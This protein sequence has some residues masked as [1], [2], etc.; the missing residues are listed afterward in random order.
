MK[1]IY[2]LRR[3]DGTG[4]IKIGCSAY[5]SARFYQLEMDLRVK[6]TALAVAP[7]DFATEGNL[8][9][10]FAAHRQAMDLCPNR[11]HVGGPTEWFSPA[12]ELLAYIDEVSRTGKISLRDDERQELV[13]AE[14]Y[15]AGET[16]Q[17][18]ASDLSIT[19]ERVRQVLRRERVASFGLRDEHKRKPEPLSPDELEMA[20]LYREGVR[21]RELARKFPD[22]CL[23]TVLRRTGTETRPAGDWLR[24]DDNDRIIA[25]IKQMYP[26]G[27]TS[28][29]IADACNLPHQ[30]AVYRYLR[31]A[32][33]R[34]S[35]KGAGT[36]LPVAEI[37]GAYLGGMTAQAIAEIHGV[38]HWTIK[39]LLRK[40]G[41]ARTREQNEAV[42]I[43]A[44][45][46]ANLERKAA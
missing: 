38:A 25:T 29:E 11:P 2:F 1:Q 21:P 9:R 43:A 27:A 3:A 22:L 20:R 24:R 30:T 4:P 17:A 36:T 12:P 16:L 46:Q 40:H 5:P 6:F 39:A 7:G 28:Q 45:R 10:K 42:R 26:A 41:A 33:I 44:V 8:H 13:I 37:V 34:P 35:R 23:A 31:M 32:G 15:T 14:R 19:R 18:I